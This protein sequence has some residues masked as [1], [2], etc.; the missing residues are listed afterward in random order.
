V[1]KGKTQDFTATGTFSDHSTLNL[2]G[3][4]T[5]TSATPAVA[6]ISAAGLATGL[7]VGTTSISARFGSI[8]GATVLTVSPAVLQSIRV[9]PAIRCIPQGTTESFTVAG[10]FS[11]RSI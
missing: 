4:V 1:A 11:D 9:T 3:Q 10:I 8:T 6:S 7:A 5:W 2:T